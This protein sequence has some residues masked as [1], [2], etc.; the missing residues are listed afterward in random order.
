MMEIEVFL[1]RSDNYGVL[2]RDPASGT[3]AA[4]DACEFAGYDMALV[5]RG[6]RLDRILVTHRHFDHIE[7][8]PGLVQKYGARVIAPKRARGALPAA[9]LYVD[10]GDR[11]EIG[12]LQAD[13]WH[14]PGHCTDHVA[15]H[16]AREKVIFVGDV[17]FTMGCG[18]IL[19]T[20]AATLHASLCR[21]ASLPDE[22]LI[23][24]GHEYTLANARF[25]AH[26]EPENAAIAARCKAV[27]RQRAAGLFTVP[28]TLAEEKATNVFLRARDVAEF[29]ARRAAK[30]RF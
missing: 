2:I 4:I 10:E 25:C 15:Y 7:G 28:T 21:L 11:V 3:V 27:E 17:L 12:T 13:I 26:V 23:Y 16:F 24:S 14:V 1:C 8:V 18:R 22:T 6:W 29:T 30:D 20:D 19:E 5:R 9:D